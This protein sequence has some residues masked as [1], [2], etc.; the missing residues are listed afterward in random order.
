MKKFRIDNI[1][2]NDVLFKGLALSHV[3][4]LKERN[5]KE[6]HTEKFQTSNLVVRRGQ[7][8]Y[9]DIHLREDYDKKQHNFNLI[10]KTGDRPTESDRSKVTV[11]FID[12]LDKAKWGMALIGTSK[13]ILQLKLSIPADCVVGK[14]SMTVKSN[15]RLIHDSSQLVYILFN[16]WVEE[17]EVYMPDNKLLDE[18]VLNDHGI[19]FQGSVHNIYPIRWYFGQFE[20]MA[21]EVA[22]GILQ[23]TGIRARDTAREV[24]RRV[25]AMV[26]ANDDGGIVLGNWGK[27]YSGGKKPWEWTGSVEILDSYMRTKRPVK[28]GQCWVF[29]GV[30]TTIMRALGVP[31]RAISNFNSAH[32]TD[33]NCTYDRFYDEKG[34]YLEKMSG[35]SSWNFHC[36]NDCWMARPDIA[37]GYGGWQ[38]VDATPQE[39][40]SG[41]YQLGPAPLK[42]VKEGNVDM[43]HDTRF[44]FTEVNADTVYW[45][46][47]DPGG[48]FVP[49]KID[50]RQVGQKLSTKEPGHNRWQRVDITEDY[51]YPE[52]T[53]LED[54]TVRRALRKSNNPLIRP[55]SKDIT[56]KV[57]TSSFLFVGD[58]LH[59][60]I[61]MHNTDRR[62]FTV[63]ATVSGNVVMYNGVAL[64]KLSPQ[65]TQVRLGPYATAAYLQD[66]QNN[67]RL[68]VHAMCQVNETGQAFADERLVT[69]WRPELRFEGLPRRWLLGKQLKFNVR[70]RNPLDKEL[71]ECVL[72][73]SGNLM[74][75]Q[76]TLP[77]RNVPARGS[78]QMSVALIPEFK[79]DRDISA[80]FS[81]AELGGFHGQAFI[82]I[83]A[84]E[85]YF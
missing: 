27:D 79:S 41:L 15:G 71:T 77:Q 17:D 37:P 56:F 43:I 81:S 36:W 25:S 66:I 46:R 54:I 55:T 85:D 21:L 72:R 29:C 12:N 49:F 68:S 83:R 76:L 59:V 78:M 7:P 73:I 23:S 40:S 9:F 28:W 70:V 24:S 74:K 18:Y 39:R 84:A 32:D 44:V 48:S 50:K 61:E 20:G 51:K 33:S 75:G 63:Q 10:F 45:K 30:T 65:L 8:I 5:S 3:D 35:D 2:Y 31:T 47:T 53:M 16:P 1:V 57:Q 58:D 67:P 4:L 22:F 82:D 64:N 80:G 13:R 6:H 19:L 34:E 11:R 42:A 26:N 69:I 14:Y 52:G 62:T 60:V 38:A